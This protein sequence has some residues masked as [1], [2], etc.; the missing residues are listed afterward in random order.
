MAL[1]MAVFRKKLIGLTVILTAFC[2]LWLTGIGAGL[3]HLKDA[4]DPIPLFFGVLGG[5]GL[6][7]FG[8]Q[9]MSDSLQKAA[10]SRLRRI[11]DLLTG[12]PIRGPA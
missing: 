1:D 2:L 8:I 3:W 12:G 5:L 7:I 10:G 6:F 11:L 4:V 9:I